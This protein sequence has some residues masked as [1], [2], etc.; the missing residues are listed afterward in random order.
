MLTSV[1]AVIDALGGTAAAADLL[2]LGRPAISNW[3][4]RGAIPPENFMMISEALTVRGL[5]AN[6]AIFGFKSR[7]AAE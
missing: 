6:P 7:E 1:E 5:H 2:G 3:K 4:F